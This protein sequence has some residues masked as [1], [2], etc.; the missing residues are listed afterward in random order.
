MTK[1]TIQVEPVVN[2]QKT[3]VGIELEV[4]DG[5][6]LE[7]FREWLKKLNNLGVSNSEEVNDLIK[8]NA[9]MRKK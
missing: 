2:Y 9:T 7:T 1:I 4:E 5:K 8:L 3:T 6:E